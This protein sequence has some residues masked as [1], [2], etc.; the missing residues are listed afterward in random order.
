[1]I[2]DLQRILDAIGDVSGIALWVVG[3]FI[4]YKLV[5]TLATTGT[6]FVVLRTFIERLFGWLE[7]QPSNKIKK[8]CF[9]DSVYRDLL[10]QMERIRTPSSKFIYDSDVRKLRKLID[11]MPD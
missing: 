7:S 10:D 9:E 8:I 1:M 4:A 11:K 3:A 6:I 2:D 5:I